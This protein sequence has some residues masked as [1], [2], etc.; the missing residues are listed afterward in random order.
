MHDRG[1][2]P[3]RAVR[4]PRLAGSLARPLGTPPMEPPRVK[5]LEPAAG[6]RIVPFEV[7]ACRGGV[8]VEAVI[9]VVRP[10]AV[11]HLPASPG[12]VEGVIDLR[13][14]IVP[15]LNMRRRFGLPDRETHL[16]DRFI[17][18][19]GGGRRIVLHVDAAEDVIELA[20]EELEQPEP[21]TYREGIGVAGV[22]KLPTGL[23]VIHDVAA[24]LSVTEKE[25]LAAALADREG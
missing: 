16:S 18:A 13:G 15:V 22:A 7:D 8:I 1:R 9:E 21:A 4:P 5:T 23:L 11:T 6:Q 2:I 3:S 12:I 19:D 17:V 10:V 20:P 25:A 14:E 24:F